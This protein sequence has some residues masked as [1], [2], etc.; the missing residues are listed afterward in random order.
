MCRHGFQHVLDVV[1]QLLR[2]LKAGGEEKVVDMDNLLKR[3]ALDVIGKSL[4]RYILTY[5]VHPCILEATLARPSLQLGSTLAHVVHH[6]PGRG[7]DSS[8]SQ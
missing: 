7:A 6:N 2:I 5:H 3:E 4:Y 1:A 8:G